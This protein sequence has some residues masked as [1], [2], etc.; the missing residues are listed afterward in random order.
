M[1]FYRLHP[2]GDERAD[3]RT[4]NMTSWLVGCLAKD[5]PTDAAAYKLSF[6][7]ES[8]RRRERRLAK[9]IKALGGEE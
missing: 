7:R 4:A 8:R 3:L 5:P 1:A 2:F 9:Q 6:Q